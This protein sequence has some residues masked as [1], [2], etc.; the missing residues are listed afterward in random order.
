MTRISRF[1]V[2][3]NVLE[4]L[5]YLLFE[6][7]SFI[8]DEEEFSAIINEL[9]SPTEIIMV[10]KRVTIIYL[11]MKRIDYVNICDVL[12]VS[13]KTV[14]KFH[15][16]MKQKNAITNSLKG[17]VKNEKIK[18]FF[19]ELFRR[20]PGAYGVNWQSAWEQKIKL[21]RRKIRGI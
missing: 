13:S 12:K 3:N 20:E 7:I 5:Y 16:I 18:D 6:V 15:S 1:P 19:E 4:K 2:E 11:L 14:A 9:F 8:D 17:I 10:A 21:G